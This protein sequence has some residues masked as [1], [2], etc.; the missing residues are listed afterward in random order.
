MNVRSLLASCLLVALTGC[1][2]SDDTPGGDDA[3]GTDG[4]MGGE[5]GDV[6]MGGTDDDP[7]ADGQAMDD[8]SLVV[9]A[10]TWTDTFLQ[11]GYTLSNDGPLEL[12]VFDVGDST[13][14]GIDEEGTVTLFLAKRDTGETDFAETPTIGGRNLSPG[15]TLEGTASRTLPIR[16]D[17]VAPSVSGLEPDSVELCIGYGRADDIIPTTRMDGTYTLDTDLEL[18]ELVCTTVERP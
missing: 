7:E 6:T 16:I 12:I 5:T 2:D 17:F 8:V 18:Q 14:T 3:S 9:N 11:I 10:S 1:G 13:T 15:Q 4:A